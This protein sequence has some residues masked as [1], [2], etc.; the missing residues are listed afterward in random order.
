MAILQGENWMWYDGTQ[1][2]FKTK[3]KKYIKKQRHELCL[4]GHIKISLNINLYNF[5]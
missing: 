3:N 2:T 5:Y 4:T 1:Q